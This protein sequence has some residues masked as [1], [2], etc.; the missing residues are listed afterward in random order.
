MDSERQV[1]RP[2]KYS[3]TEQMQCIID[4]YFKSCMKKKMHP[5]GMPV[6]DA[7]GNYIYEF[8]RPPTMSGLAVALD[9]D[10]KTLLNYSKDDQFFPTILRARMKIEM[11]TEEKLFEKE[12][13]NGSKFSLSNNF[14]WAEKQEV[15]ADVSKKLEDVL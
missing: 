2:K 1:G 7:N 3:N 4:E 13:C 14:G 12:T 9:I 6:I 15:K 8:Y 11:F 10:R 5:S